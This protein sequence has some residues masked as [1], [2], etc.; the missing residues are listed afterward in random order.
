MATTVGRYAVV[1]THNRP[2]ELATCVA[3]VGP[4]VDT[5]IV[6]DNA[7]D[8][9]ARETLLVPGA[10]MTRY[11]VVVLDYPDWPPNL[12][13]MWNVGLDAAAEYARAATHGAWDVAVLNDDAVVPDGWYEA[14][15]AAM[16]AG[17]AVVGCSGPVAAPLLKTEPDRE[18][19]TRMCPWAF[20]T[21]GEA[22]L[23]TDETIRFWWFDTDWDFRARQA[24]GV[25]LIP[26]YP[27]QNTLANSTTVGELA[28]QAGRDGETFAAKW[29]QRPW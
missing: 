16:R 22:G 20:V 29:G 24:G 14:C 2:A 17:P 1:T 3:A 5:I 25:V 10:P 4:Q 9:P 12:S 28:G 18:L 6:V 13:A 15:S 21:R 8:P 7:S 11:G 26:G 23:R 19:H 27:T